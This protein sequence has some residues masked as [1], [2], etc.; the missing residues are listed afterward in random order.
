MMYALDDSKRMVM[1]Q[2]GLAGKCPSCD[3]ALVPHCGEIVVWHW[4]HKKRLDCDPWYE[5]ETRWHRGWKESLR[6]ECC[7][8]VIGEHRADVV[9]SHFGTRMVLELQHSSI[10]PAVV[11]ERERFYGPMIWLFDGYVFERNIEFRPKWKN[12]KLNDKWEDVEEEDKPIILKAVP[13]AYYSFRWRNPR[14]SLWEVKRPMFWDFSD[15]PYMTDQQLVF[16]VKKLYPETP[17]GGWGYFITRQEFIKRWLTSSLK[18]T[19]CQS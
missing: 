8:V 12:E 5:G 6:P 11:R 17:C 10:S 14:Q 13:P 18:E 19:P 1:A 16:E 4:S 2:P 9:T 3:D 15:S 7:E